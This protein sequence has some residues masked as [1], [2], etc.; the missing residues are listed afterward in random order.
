LFLG[1]Q[2]AILG[3]W[4][5][6]N[7]WYIWSILMMVIISCKLKLSFLFNWRIF[8]LFIWVICAAIGNFANWFY[9]QQ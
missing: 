2:G 6:Y 1:I 8:S 4:H 3:A 9:H 5:W 7:D